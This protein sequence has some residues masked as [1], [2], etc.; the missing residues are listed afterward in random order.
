[1]LRSSVRGACWLLL[2]IT[3]CSAAPPNTEEKGSKVI[4]SINLAL[5]VLILLHE[6][7]TA[8]L[9]RESRAYYYR[10]CGKPGYPRNGRS[11]FSGT[12]AGSRVLHVCKAGYLLVGA[13]LRICQR[14][15]RWTPSLPQCRCKFLIASDIE[16]YENKNGGI[17][18]A[19]IHMYYCT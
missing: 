5:T 16:R 9:V 3:I 18:L 19:T 14:N 13:K 1:M 6:D 10:N 12:T 4:F 8:L 2:I 11:I 7:P 17:H 15:G